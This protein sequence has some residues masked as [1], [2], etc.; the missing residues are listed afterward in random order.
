MLDVSVLFIDLD[1]FKNVN[2]TRGHAPGDDLLCQVG[3]RLV[4]CLRIRDIVG[5]LGGD[6]FGLILITPDGSQGAEVVAN[7]I[8]KVLRPPFNLE[9]QEVIVTASIGI[10]V[11]PDDALDPDTLIKYADTAMYEAKGAGRDTYRFYTAQ[12][13]VRALEKLDLEGALRKALDQGEFVLHYQPKMQ[14][15][16]G[17]WTG[18]EALIRV[19]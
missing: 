17:Q 12:M 16:S 13:N 10:T 7:K 11:Y 19:R 15:D 14:I 9:G 5:R 3:L 1:R 6:E 4:N 18:V 8:R 2:D